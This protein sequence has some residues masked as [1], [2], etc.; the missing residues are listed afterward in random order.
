MVKVSRDSLSAHRKLVSS[1]VLTRMSPP[2]SEESAK[3]LPGFSIEGVSHS[4]TPGFISWPFSQAHTTGVPILSEVMLKGHYS[5]EPSSDYVSVV[6]PL[7]EG[8]ES[9]KGRLSVVV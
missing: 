3:P 9:L 6:F 7:L 2:T 4:S 5:K 1:M 8:K